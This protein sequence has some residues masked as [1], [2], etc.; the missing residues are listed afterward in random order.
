MFRLDESSLQAPGGRGH[1][2][3]QARRPRRVLARRDWPRAGLA[4]SP[5]ANG[6]R[7]VGLATSAVFVETRP[8]ISRY[9]HAF[10]LSPS[11]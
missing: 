1:S 2:T 3:A 4:F 5:H 6:S 11:V 7:T 10:D 9:V 8:L